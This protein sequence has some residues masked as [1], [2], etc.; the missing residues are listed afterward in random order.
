MPFLSVP[1]IDSED[2]SVC[3]LSFTGLICGRLRCLKGAGVRSFSLLGRCTSE[4][5]EGAR[6]CGGRLVVDIMIHCIYVITVGE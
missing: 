1:A 6:W 4:G 3:D 5:A 2:N